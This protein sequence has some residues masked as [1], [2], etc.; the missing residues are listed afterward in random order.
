MFQKEN[1]RITSL[2][3]YGVKKHNEMHFHIMS[4]LNLLEMKDTLEPGWTLCMGIACV[5]FPS[6]MDS[7]LLQVPT[8]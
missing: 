7:F 3:C 8:I 2:E 6:P 4:S 1:G 5:A